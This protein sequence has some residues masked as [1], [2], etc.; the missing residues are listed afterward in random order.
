MNYK[1]KKL[2]VFLYKYKPGLII[3]ASIAS[4]S[5][6]FCMY[7]FR[8]PYTAATYD[9][10]EVFGLDYKE[11]LILTQVIGY[12]ISKF[13][14]I[15]F[16]S[17]VKFDQRI[18]F[19]F[20]L[21][22]ISWITLFLFGT[23]P[24]P[25][26]LILMF[27]N[28]ISLGMIWGLVFSFLEGRRFTEILAASLS[29]SFIIS[30]GIVKSIGLWLINLGVPDFWMPFCTASIFIPPLFLFLWMLSKI[31][32]P[33]AEDIK[34]RAIRE[35]MNKSQRV[36]IFFKYSS[37]LIPLLVLHIVLTGYRDFRDKFAVDILREMGYNK[38][39]DLIIS[40]TIIG[41]TLL[42]FLGSLFMIKNNQKAYKV[43]LVII[44]TGVLIS[45]LATLLYA[46]NGI[47]IQISPYIWY[48][49]TGLG[50][51]LAYVPFHSILFDR[52]IAVFKI[53][54]NAVFFIYLADSTGYLGSLVVLIIK[55]FN[56]R[57]IS[58]LDFFIFS[59]YVLIFVGVI[60]M[61]LTFIFSRKLQT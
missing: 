57:N 2:D 50:L 33:D 22:F 43:V 11:V 41:L 18:K 8:K 54:S 52:M 31:P 26:N 21:L 53:K 30:S 3:W 56:N 45:G 25:Y 51:Y 44:S 12:T 6:Y 23:V 40:E 13:I 55:T 15:K 24:E 36:K 58:Y 39:S 42:I 9:Q 7:A 37:V 61:A 27:I 35:P 28:G 34:K 29:A 16:V 19:I 10:I 14:G 59:S 32:S 49:F 46:S 5:T 1:D 38:P 60:S 47:F 20:C 4:F 17:E 48:T